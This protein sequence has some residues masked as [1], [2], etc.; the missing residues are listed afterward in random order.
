MSYLNQKTILKPISFNGVGLHSGVNVNL[1]LKPAEADTGILFKRID[2]K[3][4]N[5]LIPSFMNV[6]NTSLNTTISNN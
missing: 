5:I 6:S 1:T 4:N 2:L 3:K